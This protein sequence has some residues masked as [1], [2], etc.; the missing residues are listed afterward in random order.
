MPA[1]FVLDEEMAINAFAAG[2]S[3]NDF[4]VAVSRGCLEQ[5]SR[6][7]LQGVVA[8]EFSH[9][10][11]GDML[12]NIRLTGWLYGIMGLALLGRVLFEVAGRSGRSRNKDG[13]QI[14]AAIF[15]FGLGLLLIGWI[16][17]FF[18][19]AIQAAIS[20]QRE[21]LADSSAVQF[22]RNPNGISGALKKIAGYPT[23]SAIAHPR[24]SAISHMF[25]ASALNSLFAT[26]PPLEER[27][28]L[29]DPQFNP[30]VALLTIGASSRTAAA[31]PTAA[32]A[33]SDAAPPIIARAKEI[34]RRAGSLAPEQIQHAEN[35]LRTL[36]P[37]LAEAAQDPFSAM[38]LI[39][40]LLLDANPAI[41]TAQ[42]SSLQQA[43]PPAV[44]RE[45]HR[46]LPHLR[47]LP[48]RVRLP[49]TTL[50]TAALRRLS[51]AQYTHFR[52]SV[53]LLIEADLSIDL[54]EYALKKMLCGHL[55]PCF[56]PKPHRRA[57][58]PPNITELLP[59]CAIL[60]S[61]LAHLGHES[62]QEQAVAFQAGAGVLSI[63][64][65]TSFTLLP[66]DQCNLAQVDLSLNRL[67]PAAASVRKTV[68]EA[69]AMTIA[70]DGIIQEGEAELI[71]AI[72]ATLG[73]PIPPFV[74]LD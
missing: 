51:P 55:D 49:L 71:R 53:D 10:L 73:C 8:H 22:T 62:A 6:D 19:R 18:A 47:G 23:G 9:I 72:G 33:F 5:L 65:T 58:H 13:N 15:V 45:L 59:D 11:N 3:T 68:L 43:E 60:L 40:A 14:T 32:A 28:R 4:A 42:L 26:H 74:N 52:A 64:E 20:R 7:E 16:G 67:A 24:A 1:V 70:S 37:L 61:C 56:H 2:H 63:P 29:L 31:A 38:A 69:C 66:L 25:F 17:Q 44:L 30:E 34:T 50:A 48:V 46:L 35:L 36:P 39:Y 57:A 41:A 54:F 21:H 27:I 12:R